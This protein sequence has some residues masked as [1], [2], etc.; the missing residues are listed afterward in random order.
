MSSQKRILLLS[1]AVGESLRAA[2]RLHNDVIDL[3]LSTNVRWS[4][5]IVDTIGQQC[6]KVIVAA[7]W[8]LDP[9]HDRFEIIHWPFQ[10]VLPTWKGTMIGDEKCPQLCQPDLDKHVQTLS[11]LLS[12]PWCYKPHVKPLQKELTA[13]VEV[14]KQCLSY[15]Q[16]HN[17][18][19]ASRLPYDQ[20][21]IIFCWKPVHL[22]LC[23]IPNIS[24]CKINLHGRLC[25]IP[26][27]VGDYSPLDRH[28]WK[29]WLNKLHQEFP[30]KMYWYCHA[31]SLGTMTFIWQIPSNEP[32]NST[33]TTQALNSRQKQ[34]CTRQ[35]WKDFSCNITNLLKLPLVFFVLC[36]SHWYTIVLQL[37]QQ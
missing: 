24:N 14:M 5:G 12:Q 10:L 36:T 26:V 32:H 27:F 15:L 11:S 29:H 28:V 7:L 17:Q 25:T 6:I 30:V 21:R 16:K 33:L 3:L 37:R 18:S 20:S 23:V 13:L 22:C 34:Y 8:Y 9:H 2:Q 35:M 31:N 4:P 19:H 1:K